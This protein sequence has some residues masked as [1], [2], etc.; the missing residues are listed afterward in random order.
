MPQKKKTPSRRKKAVPDDDTLLYDDLF[1][2]CLRNGLIEKTTYGY[3]FKPEFF[4][5]LALYD[6]E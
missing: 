4:D 2:R 5:T 6:E 1:D 3:Y